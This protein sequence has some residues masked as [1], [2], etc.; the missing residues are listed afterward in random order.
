MV[1]TGGEDGIVRVWTRRTHELI[2]QIPAHHSN[3]KCDFCRFKY[4]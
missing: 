2:I 1:I 3:V 4:T